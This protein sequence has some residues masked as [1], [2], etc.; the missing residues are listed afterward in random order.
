MRSLVVNASV[1]YNWKQRQLGRA[2]GARL[3]QCVLPSASPTYFKYAYV[4]VQS[5]RVHAFN[6]TP[7]YHDPSYDPK[8][9]QTLVEPKVL[10]AKNYAGA[11]I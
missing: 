8:R 7:L 5:V 4:R 1:I 9:Q 10:H 11:N 3:N 6:P 2:R